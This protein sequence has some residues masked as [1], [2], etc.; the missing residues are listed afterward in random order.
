MR[1]EFILLNKRAT[2]GNGIKHLKKND[3]TMGRI[4]ERVGPYSFKLDTNYYDS[5]LEAILAQQLAWSAARVIIGRFKGLYGGRFPTPKEY[6]STSA[7]KLRKVGISPQ[8]YSYIKDLCER[9]EKGSLKLEKLDRM[10]DEE[11][12][13]MLDEVRGIGRWTAEMFLIFSMGR[14][15]VLPVD[16]LGIR[17]ALQREYRL[18]R[19]PERKDFERIS[20]NWHPYRSVATLYLWRSADQ[21]VREKQ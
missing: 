8:K 6:L 20:K 19:L 21:K 18:R 17:K 11:I 12:I 16:D 4:I 14:S 15:N 13:T 1:S 3:R 9:L 5:I 10:H 2:W 7:G